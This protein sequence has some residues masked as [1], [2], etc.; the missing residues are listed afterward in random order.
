MFSP[1]RLTTQ[2]SVT[3]QIPLSMEFSRQRY[4]SRLPFPTTGDIPDP[5]V[6]PESPVSPALA[7]RFAF[8]FFFFF[9]HWAILHCPKTKLLFLSQNLPSRTFFLI[10]IN[11]IFIL[12]YLVLWK[13]DIVSCS[14]R[15]KDCSP[16]G[17]SVCGM[18]QERILWSVANPF[19][20]RSSWPRDPT[21]VSR[22]TGRLYCLSP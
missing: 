17:S 11:D 7:G 21:Q 12:H 15:P 20:R 18:L 16:I 10:F 6:E 4:W 1:V 19:S 9:N 3:Y 22:L 14:S 13:S 5:E 8:F 2:G